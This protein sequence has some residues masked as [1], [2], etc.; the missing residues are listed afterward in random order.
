MKKIFLP[1]F[2]VFFFGIELKSQDSTS[3]IH[4][5]CTSSLID[6]KWEMRKQEYIH[7]FK[8]LRSLNCDFYCVE[9]CH[10]ANSPTFLDE[11]CNH[12]CYVRS[13]NPT[14]KNK[15]VNECISMLK[16][17]DYFDFNDDDMIIK[18]TGRYYFENDYFVNL[19]L[20]NPNIDAFVRYGGQPGD[21]VTPNHIFTGCF[22]MRFKFFKDMLRTINFEKMEQDFVNNILSGWVE[23]IVARYVEQHIDPAKVM[24]VKKLYVTAN[25]FFDG[26]SC[27]MT[28]W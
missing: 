5:L 26:S 17:L 25:V 18:L 14:L 16:F 1:L 24:H 4:V 27:S 19:I 9:N 13:N 22:A 20:A 15:G 12:V 11:Y 3:K 21:F 8:I 6:T 28:K 2:L 10:L 7:S 23:D